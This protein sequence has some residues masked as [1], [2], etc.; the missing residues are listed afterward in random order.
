MAEVALVFRPSP[1]LG[2]CPVEGSWDVQVDS[3]DG[4]VFIPLTGPPPTTVTAKGDSTRRAVIDPNLGPVLPFDTGWE[5]A[6]TSFPTEL[7]SE[8]ATT[9]SWTSTTSNAS[10][11][12]IFPTGYLGQT[13]D[14]WVRTG[15]IRRRI[16]SSAQAKPSRSVDAAT[17]IRLAGLPAVARLWWTRG[18]ASVDAAAADGRVILRIGARGMRTARILRIVRS[19]ASAN[20]G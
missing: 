14:A 6:D 11:D 15:D 4:G 13:T 3:G 16:E 9:R 7:Y 19:I 18:R 5:A 12:V 1:H 8:G 10:V 20:Q 17:V 2:S